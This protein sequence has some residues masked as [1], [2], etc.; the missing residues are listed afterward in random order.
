MER[1]NLPTV[2]QKPLFVNNTYSG[3]IIFSDGRVYST[4]SMKFLKEEIDSHGYHRVKITFDGRKDNRLVSVHRLVASAFISNPENKPDVNHIDG[5]KSN[6]NVSNLEWC[7]K[8]ENIQHAINH[9]LKLPTYG[10]NH[11]M[12]KYTEEQIIEICKL[13]ESGVY[14][15]KDIIE[16]TGVSYNCI[17]HIIRRNTWTRI[18]N[19]Y[20]I[21]NYCHKKS[22]T[23]NDYRKVFSLLEDNQLSPYDIS[24]ITGVD[25]KTVFKI[26]Y[27]ISNSDIVNELY[28][29]YDISNYTISDKIYTKQITTEMI[30]YYSF[31]KSKKYKN[32][33]IDRIIS[34]KFNINELFV[35]NEFKK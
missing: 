16:M 10:E 4:K 35:H 5:N 12:T 6:N 28:P 23:S 2:K 17:S 8:S 24:D 32:K 13:L 21:N 26:I 14:T 15:I 34:K 20:E 27:N 19:N 11:G 1:I 22:Y 33:I 18:S 25:C 3:Y 31:L 30:D 29:E 9:G 7:T